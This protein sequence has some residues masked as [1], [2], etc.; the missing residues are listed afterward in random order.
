[1]NIKQRNELNYLQLY[2]QIY[3][4]QTRNELIIVHKQKK[5]SN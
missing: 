5:L 3:L 4:L 2:V 1:M